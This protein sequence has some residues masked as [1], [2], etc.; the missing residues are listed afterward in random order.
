VYLSLNVIFQLNSKTP[1]FLTFF[2][3]WRAPQQMPRT[4][5]SLKAYCA[6]LWWRWLV[7]FCFC[8]GARV[9]WNW[10]GKTEVLGRKTCPSATLCTTNPTW[11]RDLRM[12]V[13]TFLVVLLRRTHSRSL[14][15]NFRYT[16]CARVCIY[17]RTRTYIY[18]YICQ[19]WIF[20]INTRPCAC[21]QTLY[22]TV[23]VTRDTT[24]RNLHTTL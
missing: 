17:T 12:L 16:L 13:W 24:R 22:I 9:E 11:T 8:N 15:K 20:V 18:I 2:F 23:Y 6:T 1:H 21:T 4:H 19:Y 7:S 3:N 14:S 5:C 10:Q